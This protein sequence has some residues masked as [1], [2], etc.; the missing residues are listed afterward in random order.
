VHRYTMSKHS[1]RLALNLRRRLLRHVRRELR[2]HHVS[3][4]HWPPRHLSRPH[5]P[6]RHLSRPHWPPRHLL[7]PHWPPRRPELRLR[8]RLLRH[9]R[10]ELLLRQSGLR[11][12][13]R[14][15]YFRNLGLC[16]RNLGVA[17]QDE[18]E[19]TNLE[20]LR[21]TSGG[22]SQTRSSRGK[23]DDHLRCPTSV[24]AFS[25]VMRASN[26]ASRAAA[27]AGAGTAAAL[28]P[29]P[30]PQS[31]PT[32]ASATSQSFTGRGCCRG[33]HASAAALS[34]STNWSCVMRDSSANS[35]F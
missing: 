33:A 6:P 18:I 24:F 16:L 9:V 21:D 3:R 27:F 32:A 30:A 14:G 13:S 17:A 26:A 34:L 20:K 1:R 11:L 15:L 22:W 10:R 23:P 35:P 4:L 29:P 7:P 25:A 5:W 31:R 2:L 12:L 19:K 28:A 8:H